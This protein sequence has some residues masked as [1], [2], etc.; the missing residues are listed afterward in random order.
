MATARQEVEA[1]AMVGGEVIGRYIG[2]AKRAVSW[3]RRANPG[4]TVEVRG[5]Q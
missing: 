5:A 1:L 3:A 2:P 4:A